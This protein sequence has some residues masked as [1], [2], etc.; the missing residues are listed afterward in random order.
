MTTF[1]PGS[2]RIACDVQGEGPLV[3]FLHGIGGNRSN[4]AEQL[5][6]LAPRARAV[7]WDARGYGD[8]EDD[9]REGPPEFADFSADLLRL[10]EHFG[11]EQAHVVG[12][13]MGGRIAMDF[14][15]R[16]PT[17]V[18]SLVLADTHLGFGN[19]SAEER[20]AFI[21]LREEPLRA[22]RTMR[23]L[24]PAVAATL[25]GDDAGE[26][27]QKRLVESIAAIKPANYL[28]SIAC[29]VDG[30]RFDALEQITAPT[31]V[32]AG[33]ADRLTPLEMAHEIAGRI[34]GARCMQIQRA[35]HLSNIEAPEAFNILLDAF[36]P[37]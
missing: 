7:A 10:I 24:A 16:H 11:A 26:D 31:M 36:L 29:M 35:G 27:V 13:S 5:A 21:R 28:R 23:D 14:A 15:V 30:D 4:W 33:G 8:S 25:M 37:L 3:I 17:R 20:A 6:H 34:P 9:P 19:F 18:A 22:G 2:P 32:M 12:L 1:V